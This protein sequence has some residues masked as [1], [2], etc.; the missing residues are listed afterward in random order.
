MKEALGGSATE[1]NFNGQVLSMSEPPVD[2]DPVLAG[3][4][5][6]P[7]LFTPFFFLFALDRWC[8]QPPPR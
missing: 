1:L 3:N 6:R 2:R 5:Y 7:F 4:H 8:R